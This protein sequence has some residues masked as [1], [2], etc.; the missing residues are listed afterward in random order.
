LRAP[1][2]AAC[3]AGATAAG[4]VW[5][6]L[7]ALLL[8]CLREAAS[9]CGAAADVPAG[10]ELEVLL[11]AAAAEPAGLGLLAFTT[12]RLTVP[13]SPFVADAAADDVEG[14]GAAELSAVLEGLAA[15]GFVPAERACN[16]K[17]K[18]LRVRTLL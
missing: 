9:A 18:V 15:R 3:S 17:C 14:A 13:D 5:A 11:V 1:L 16:C 8:L 10:A 12:R 2:A 4:A 6:L 7:E